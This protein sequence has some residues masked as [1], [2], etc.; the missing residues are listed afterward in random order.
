MLSAIAISMQ[1]SFGL[2]TP[3]LEAFNSLIGFKNWRG[4]GVK[5]AATMKEFVV[6][7]F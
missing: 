3:G 2:K 1:S 6:Y 5:K 4:G 7:F